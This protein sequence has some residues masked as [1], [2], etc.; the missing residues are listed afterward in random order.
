MDEQGKPVRLMGSH[1]DITKQKDVEAKL[2]AELD[3]RLQAE[4]AL[5]FERDSL[6]RRVEERTIELSLANAGLV[7]ANHAKDEFLST[8]SHELRTP[9]NAI[10]NLSES[11][12]EDTY[13]AIN[14]QQRHILG[15]I[16]ESGEHLLSLINDILDVSKAESG[17]IE[18]QPEPIDLKGL[19]DSA[20]RLINPQA[21]KKRLRIFTA[22]DSNLGTIAADGR[23][24]K[25]MLVNLLGNAVK[26]TPQGGQ[27]GLEVTRESEGESIRFTVW[28][29]GIGIPDDK[30]ALLFQPFMQL[31]T[32][33][34]R[35]YAG[36]GLGLALVRRLAELHGGS[37]GVE[38]KPGE[39]SRFW[40]V[41]PVLQVMDSAGAEPL[42]ITGEDQA[43]F[44]PRRALI[45][46]DSEAAADH[47]ARY[48]S[49]LNTEVIVQSQGESAVQTAVQTKPD[50]ILL[51]IMLPDTSGW[52]VLA[53]LKTNPHTREIPVVIISVVD[54]RRRGVSLGAV[55]Y[56]L[57]PITREQLHT[58]LLKAS[59]VKG[60]A[61]R[62]LL[63]RPTTPVENREQ[64]AQSGSLILFAED[65]LINLEIYIDYLK[66]KGYRVVPAI[67]GYEAIER[68]QEFKPDLILMDIQ[69]PAM[70]GLE[71][72]RRLRAM[73]EFT[74]API[75]ALTALAMPGDRE[76]CL[77]AGANAYLSKPISL[78]LLM[79]EI[80]A[81][82]DR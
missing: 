74:T 68:A 58:A 44:A 52:Q 43:I 1:I 67:N 82:L 29:S 24:L 78:K 37:V 72:I 47:I 38:S 36:T 56:L 79:K 4:Q 32:A 17:R 9:M 73:P 45:I 31:D 69:M 23:R 54:E 81:L 59:N 12:Q 60:K 41:I 66:S 7:R 39:G 27:V 14:P 13:G 46:E 20:L 25:Q 64:T 16:R 26:F 3:A 21:M 49:E 75:I 35:E 62:V 33:L 6:A 11:L 2:Q 30:I 55:E 19:I 53:S 50:V 63:I 42:E 10:L 71:A 34:S 61:N 15:T 5:Q 8:M 76:R 57:K 28:D 48:L 18:L 80:Q 40:F 70:D 77:A 51:D 22:L 65:N